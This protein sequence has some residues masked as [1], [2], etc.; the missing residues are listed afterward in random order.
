MRGWQRK[1]N[2]VLV[3]VH[4]EQAIP[5]PFAHLLDG[6]S[7]TLAVKLVKASKERVP[8]MKLYSKSDTA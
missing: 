8:V 6:L 1:A 3:R 7:Q 2:R 5:S 4:V